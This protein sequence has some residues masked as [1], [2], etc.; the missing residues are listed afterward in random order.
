MEEKIFDETSETAEV[1]T[2]T[3]QIDATSVDTDTSTNTSTA[4]ESAAESTTDH[5]T[6]PVKVDTSLADS[7]DTNVADTQSDA[8]TGITG[9][10]Q[11]D[12]D[13]APVENKKKRNKKKVG[14]PADDSESVAQVTDTTD[15]ALAV[16]AVPALPTLETLTTEIKMRLH[17]LGENIIEVGKRLIQA[18]ELVAHGVWLDWLKVNFNLGES[19]A[20][21]FMQVAERFSGKQELIPVLS[22]T[23]M[24]AM[25]AL[26][27]GDE[28]KFIEEQTAAGNDVSKMSVRETKK[29]VKE[30][31]AKTKKDNDAP[32]VE[33]VGS[34]TIADTAEPFTIDT[35]ATIAAAD[36]DFVTLTLPKTLY[37]D[38]C[39]LAKVKGVDSTA[40]IVG[41]IN[42]YISDNAADM[43]NFSDTDN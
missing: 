13:T 42:Q 24:I 19:S 18:K 35:Q 31:K 29:A 37:R 22:T 26:P 9:N 15:T 21:K 30:Y 1:T 11:A 20:R 34:D 12:S 41:F 14:K 40:L 4:D 10:V 36:S 27:E 3:A 8:V 28:E 38:F 39:T 33:V 16:T 5:D 6:T 7:T 32:P 17:Q 43:I 23:Q 2:D 25:L